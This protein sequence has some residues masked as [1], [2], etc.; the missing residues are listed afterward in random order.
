MRFIFLSFLFLGCAKTNSFL[1]KAKLKSNIPQETPNA[2]LGSSELEALN[3]N[4]FPNY[5]DPIFY[6]LIILLIVLLT[7][8]SFKLFKRV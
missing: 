5:S 3:N 7:S 1:N 2:P 8:F 6:F 4:S